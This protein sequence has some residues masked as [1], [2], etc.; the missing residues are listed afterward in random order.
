MK[1]T[2]FGATGGVGGHVVRQALDA[3]HTVTAVV[4]D[5]A[6]LAVSHPAL[7]VVTVPGL[8]DP[9]PLRPA[10]EGRDAAISAVGPGSRKQIGIASRTAP[11]IL[12]ALELAGVRRFVAVSAMPL[13]PIPDG[14]RWLTKRVFVPLF[15]VVLRDLITDLTAM[16]GAITRSATDWTVVRPPRFTDKPVT[17]RYRMAI[18]GTVPHGL[19][20]SRAD[21]AHAMLAVLTN[22][23]TYNQPVGIAR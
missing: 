5:P 2:V 6:R 3:G 16:E 12:R 21:V 9:V 18:G 19:S 17:G 15:R 7:E 14:E 11:S 13:G 4:R 8:T 23:A 1:L 10:L 20:I 22:P